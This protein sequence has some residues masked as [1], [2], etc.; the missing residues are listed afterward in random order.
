MTPLLMA[1]IA[2]GG[3]GVVTGYLALF[4]GKGS[5]AHRTIGLWF[6]VAMA[7]MGGTAAAIT[8]ITGRGAGIGGVLVIYLVVTGLTT[9]RPLRNGQRY[10]DLACLTVGALF[11]V[12]T[13]QS[14]IENVVRFGGVRDGVPAGMQFFIGAITGLAVL[15]DIRMLRTGIPGGAKRI[16]RHLW[17][18]CFGLFIAT[19]SFFLGQ[20][21]EIPEALRIWPMLFVLALAPLVLLLYWMWRVRIRKSLR[22]ITTARGR[23]ALGGPMTAASEAVP[24]PQ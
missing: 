7:I 11:M 8:I 5:P 21:D 16:A 9:V 12:V 20:A 14:G 2:A 22:G 3:A 10:L 19:G 4:A 1:H 23:M 24:A 15:G 6:V 17:R 18:M 13:I